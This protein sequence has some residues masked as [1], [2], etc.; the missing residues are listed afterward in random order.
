MIPFY[1]PRPAAVHALPSLGVNSLLNVY[2]MMSLGYTVEE[3]YGANVD[4]DEALKRSGS[5]GTV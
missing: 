5:V 4:L 3:T 1:A 2:N